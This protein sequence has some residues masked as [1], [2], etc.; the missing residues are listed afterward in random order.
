MIKLLKPGDPCP[1][2]GKPIPEGVP[3]ER[4]LLLS[5]LAAR[6]ELGGEEEEKNGR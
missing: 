2:C 6:A 1:C 4:M 3:R 5:Y